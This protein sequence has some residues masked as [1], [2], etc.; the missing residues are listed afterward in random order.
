MGLV[1]FGR[2]SHIKILEKVNFKLLRRVLAY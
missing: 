1:Y 2:V